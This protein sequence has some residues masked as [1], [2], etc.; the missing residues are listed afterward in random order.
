MIFLAQNLKALRKRKKMTQQDLA[1]AVGVKRPS[2]GA[3]EEGRAEPKLET[4]LRMAQLFN[5]EVTDLIARNLEKS[6]EH[7]KNS[8]KVLPIQVDPAG[9]ERV[10]LVPEKARA[11]YLAGYGDPEFVS[12]LPDFSLPLKEL[13]QD[14]TYRAFQI[15]GDSMLPIPEGSYVIGEYWQDTDVL[16][17]NERYILIT[18]DDGMVFKRIGKQGDE[19]VQLISDNPSFLPY[20]VSRDSILEAWIAKAYISFDFDIQDSTDG[21]KKLQEQLDRLEAKMD[22]FQSKEIES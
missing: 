13:P 5:V 8:L 9:R 18:N 12:K 6:S 7:R 11:G 17:S 2:I 15:T 3:Y 4:L 1:E 10:S 16:R 19:S 14:R 21:F 22:G 20:A